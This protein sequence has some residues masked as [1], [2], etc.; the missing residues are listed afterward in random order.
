MLLKATILESQYSYE[1]QVLKYKKKERA[2]WF[3]NNS[4]L[5]SDDRELFYGPIMSYELRFQLSLSPL[6]QANVY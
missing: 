6:G 1:G 5:L 3:R 4:P 2:R